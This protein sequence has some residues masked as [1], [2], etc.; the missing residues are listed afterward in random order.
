MQDVFRLYAFSLLVQAVLL[1]PYAVRAQHFLQTGWEVLF[2]VLDA[3]VR[4]APPGLPAV[5]LSCRAFSQFRLSKQHVKLLFPEK[6]K[7]GADTSVV[8]FDKTGT[9]TGSTVSV[10]SP[11][12]FPLQIVPALD[13]NRHPV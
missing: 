12:T 2:R 9:L 11:T 7:L 10:L 6:L 13:T 5:L 3:V 8:C 4:A 1:I